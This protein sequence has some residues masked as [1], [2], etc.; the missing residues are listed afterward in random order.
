MC[1]RGAGFD[2]VLQLDALEATE[3]TFHASHIYVYIRLWLGNKRINQFLVL[4]YTYISDYGRLIY[5]YI[6]FECL[7]H[8]YRSDVRIWSD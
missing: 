2:V 4:W 6:R 3:G 1:I 7:K 5:V 8:V